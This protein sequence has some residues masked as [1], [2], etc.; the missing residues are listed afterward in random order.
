[1]RLEVTAELLI[2]Y[3]LWLN[4]ESEYVKCM[5]EPLQELL[6]EIIAGM[7]T[8]TVVSAGVQ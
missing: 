3:S 2:H 6:T 5:A 4:I 7:S 1:M 8:N